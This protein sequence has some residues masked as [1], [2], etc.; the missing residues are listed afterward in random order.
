MGLPAMAG[1]CCA[2]VRKFAFEQ[3]GTAGLKMHPGYSPVEVKKQGDGRLTIVVADKDG[4]QL[5]I[6]DNDHVSC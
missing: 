1:V 4:N 6:A 3:Y 2:Q 5:E